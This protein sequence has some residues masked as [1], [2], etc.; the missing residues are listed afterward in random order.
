VLSATCVALLVLG[1]GCGDDT[2]ISDKAS[3]AADQVQTKA[4]EVLARGQAEAFRARVK[5]L[6]DGDNAKWRDMSL[7]QQAAKDL[8]GSP[9]V[10]GIADDDGDGKD[11]DGRIEIVVNDSRACIAVDGEI[12]VHGGAC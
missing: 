1:A 8:P 11:D 7:L 12:D 4:D 6:A 9:D 2:S 3:D 10:S 5:D